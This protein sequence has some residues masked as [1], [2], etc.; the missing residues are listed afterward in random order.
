MD[1]NVANGLARTPSLLLR[2]TPLV[3]S[4]MC[5]VGLLMYL[6]HNENA[7][8]QVEAKR[9]ARCQ[10]EIANPPPPF[11]SSFDCVG[12]QKRTDSPSTPQG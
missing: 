1:T 4:L 10:A 9:D 2:F 6:Q 7:R 11:K 3:L 8:K 12:W 5:A